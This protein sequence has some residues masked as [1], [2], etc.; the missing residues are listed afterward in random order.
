MKTILEDKMDQRVERKIL[1]HY[2]NRLTG[3]IALIFLGLAIFLSNWLSFE[4]YLVLLIGA[5]LLAWGVFFQ[6][7]R[8]TLFGGVLSGIGSGILALQ[9]PWHL[10]LT[11]LGR[12]GVFLVCFALG[13]LLVT[14][15]T[16][17]ADSRTLWWPLI[18]GGVMAV[19]GIVLLTT[20]HWYLQFV[21]F[22]WPVVLILVGLYL[23]LLWSRSK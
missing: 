19:A 8:L 11:D 1:D 10:A 13:W 21:I 5:A 6:S 22:I 14:V 16:S 18:P 20:I 7:T 4:L 2:A 3:G 15:L 17:L 12:S 23:V 9:G